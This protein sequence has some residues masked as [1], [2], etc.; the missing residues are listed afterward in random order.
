MISELKRLDLRGEYISASHIGA[1]IKH[2]K[3]NIEKLTLLFAEL[4]QNK[5]PEEKVLRSGYIKFV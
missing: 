4:E 1:I 5:E 3:G 2:Y